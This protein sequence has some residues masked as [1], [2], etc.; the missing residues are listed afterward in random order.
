MSDAPAS[1]TEMLGRVRAGQTGSKDQLLQRVYDELRQLARHRMGHLPPGATLQPTA[2]V[3]EAYMKMIGAED[4]EW[5][6]R[7]HF[8][9]AAARA[10]RNILVDQARERGALK[11]GGDRKRVSF[12]ERLAPDGSDPLEPMVLEEALKKLETYDERKCEIVMLR[13]YAG[14]TIAEAAKVL[15]ISTAT[16]EREWKFTK[17]WL[18]REL[19]NNAEPSSD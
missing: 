17:T 11:R 3:H 2:L 16:L 18:H 5:E 15:G 4:T 10:M 14:L 9:G 8:F 19:A 12:E 1:I 7:R 13:Y 6:S